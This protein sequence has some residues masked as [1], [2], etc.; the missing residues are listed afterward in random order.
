MTH[1]YRLSL[2]LCL[3][4]M[5]ALVIPAAR[6]T[7]AQEETRIICLIVQIN[8]DCDRI[9]EAAKAGGLPWTIDT[10]SSFEFVGQL[11]QNANYLQ[12]VDVL[13]VS[14]DSADPLLN[15]D[16][17]GNLDL[18]V[19]RIGAYVRAGG[20]LLVLDPALLDPALL[21]SEVPTRLL[22]P[23]LV[24]PI[25]LVRTGLTTPELTR[26]G[27]FT[28]GIGQIN[29]EFLPQGSVSRVV[30]INRLGEAWIP[31]TRVGFGELNT[32][33]LASALL[34]DGR[35]VFVPNGLN[36][37]EF[38][39]TLIDWICCIVIVG[40]DLRA[41]A[42]EV[43]QA[44]QDLNNSVD[45]V[46]GKRTY[47]RFHVSSPQPRN[48]VTATLSGRYRFPI[49]GAPW[50]PLGV[51]TPINPGGTITVKPFPN[52]G[53]INDSFLFELP[54]SWRNIPSAQ[55]ELTARI[56]PAN[57]VNDLSLSNNQIQRT[58]TLLR[59]PNMRLR[60]YNVRYT[61]GNNTYQASNFHLNALESWLRR[62]Y[63]IRN[64]NVTR[65]SYT[66]PNAGLPNVD[67]LN[68]NMAIAR[69]FGIIF[70]SV[71]INTF[72]YGIVDDGGDF[73]RGK[74]LGI[75]GWVS[76]G[77][78][79][80]PGGSWGWDTDGSYGDWYGGHEIAH[81]LG[82]LHA[83]F[84]GAGG[85]E[86][87]PFTHPSGRISPALSGNTAIY[88]F[89]ITNRTIYPPDWRDVM[90]YCNNQWVSD[91]TY[92]GIRQRFSNIGS[93]QLASA[94]LQQG[95]FLLIGGRVELATGNGSLG[96]IHVLDGT[97]TNTTTPGEDGWALVLVKS[98]G[99][100]TI[101][102]FTPAKV[103]DDESPEEPAIFAEMV[104]WEAN[105]I[106]IELRRGATV[107]DQ[108]VVSANAPTVNVTAPTSG[109]SA[110]GPI[111]IRWTASDL[112]GDSLTY[113]VLFSNDNGATWR[114][115]AT[116]LSINELTINTASLPGGAQ[117]RFRVVASDGVLSGQGDS[118]ALDIPTKAPLIE[119]NA[120]A[121][122]AFFYPTQPVTFAATAYDL[123]DG[124]LSFEEDVSN[125]PRTA[126]AD[127]FSWVSDK[128][129]LLGTGASLTIDSL[130]TGEHTITL[131]VTDS[132]GKTS[133]EEFK[134][135][136]ASAETPLDELLGGS[137]LAVAPDV[138]GAV[139]T[140]GSTAEPFTVS[141]NVLSD[142]TEP[143]NWT[144]TVPSN[145]PW[146]RVRVGSTG[147]EG[148]TASGST[149]NNLIVIVD[150][151]G[152]ALGA[153]NTEVTVTSGGQTRILTVNLLKIGEQVYLPLV[154]R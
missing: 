27:R 51:L 123:E 2:A 1:R 94:E 97:G 121:D 74:A 112:D 126:A 115:V 52:R 92:E 55:L 119:L 34:G 101:Y 103:E 88:G 82:R 87:V 54:A 21:D 68:Q 111:T 152:L 128:D 22:D 33:S 73:M 28:P 42:L 98:A 136:I 47:V 109:L 12:G 120:P 16:I 71:N 100:P 107:V 38:A 127:A 19:Q 37:F 140:I 41:N 30:P 99:A 75:P 6:P 85:G 20:Q 81:S 135:T 7:A 132:E 70:G 45:L 18:P 125:E 113:A 25:Q 134:I 13:V 122:G 5:L 62:A 56:D 67:T 64:L 129:G 86:T 10:I 23:T 150:P 116:D 77:P 11:L 46:A 151:S 39:A 110:D 147:S 102:P 43:T 65:V 53:L 50:I 131:T 24:A 72:Y 40:P 49:P 90:T 59:G 154:R 69:L 26:A 83:E 93:F 133:T 142:G 105:T 124:E 153:Y 104:P 143:L 35:V 31:Q 3:L 58:V 14:R 8:A 76:S 146:V 108:R 118:V 91:F 138:I 17:D 63:P 95:S 106:R 137:Q 61:M 144:A 139:A 57:A 66:Y 79:G 4:L 145:A 114:S 89:D 80:A 44:I 32:T 141:T 48:G 148:A 36:S 149:P 9:A 78:T 29:R 130:S 60:L 84:C 117:S 96:E 15:P